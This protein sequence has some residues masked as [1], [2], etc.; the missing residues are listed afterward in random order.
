MNKLF[1]PPSTARQLLPE[2]TRMGAV[3]LSV[4]D[5]ER[6]LAVWRDVVGLGLVSR[7][8][9][10][11][12]LGI[13]DAILLTLTADA[14]APAAPRALGLYHVAIHVPSRR[15]LA[16]FVARAVG[17]G[18]RVSPTDHLV[19]EAVYMWDHDGSASN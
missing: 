8:G 17:A 10:T 7:D 2:G 6:A 4:T 13:G 1:S 14:S 5:A 12:S 15:D 19:T 3:H 11:L 18:M 16:R 9:D